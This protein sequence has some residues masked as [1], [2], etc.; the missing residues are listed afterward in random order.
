MKGG[1]MKARLSIQ[2]FGH[3]AW[4]KWFLYLIRFAG[5]AYSPFA[6]A[7]IGL[8]LGS[9]TVDPMEPRVTDLV[10]ETEH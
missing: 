10:V 3:A 6:F 2:I 1:G 7:Y 4:K 9:G 8:G 5:L